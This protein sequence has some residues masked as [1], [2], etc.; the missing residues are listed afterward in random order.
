MYRFEQITQLFFGHFTYPLVGL[1][2]DDKHVER[3]DWLQIDDAYTMLTLQEDL[4]GHVERR[5]AYGLAGSFERGHGTI[6]ATAS[7]C[8]D[9]DRTRIVDFEDLARSKTYGRPDDHRCLVDVLVVRRER[10]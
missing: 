3:N 4:L 2:S 6:G 7:D 1:S 5:E 8:G 9:D 10:V